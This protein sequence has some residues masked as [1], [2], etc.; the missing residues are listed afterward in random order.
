MKNYIKTKINLFKNRNKESRNLEIGPG[1]VRIPGFETLNIANSPVTDYIINASKPLP[2]PNGTFKVLYA[3]HI[4]EHIPWYKTLD[5]LKEWQRVIKI[6]GEIEIWVPDGYKIAKAFINA[7][8]GDNY[9]DLDG[10]YKFNPQKD[11]CIWA[12][13]R[14]FTYGDGK[15]TL[16]HPNWHL[17][18]F[19]YR[20]L[21][22]LL[23][24][25]GFSE[26]RKMENSEV[27][28]YDHKWINL[29]IKGRKV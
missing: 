14:I 10:W 12:S 24:E 3:S 9:L 21:E 17:A 22:N 28:G 23:Q 27:R 8:D 29:G 5:V 11:P 26:I 4:L 7:E 15:G 16:G 6:G 18:I 1:E 2:F 19:S 25:A 13:G 20:Y